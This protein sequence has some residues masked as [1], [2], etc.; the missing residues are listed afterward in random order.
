MNPRRCTCECEED[1]LFGDVYKAE[2]VHDYI[3]D[4]IDFVDNARHTINALTAFGQQTIPRDV[5]L[6]IK[7]EA[8]TILERYK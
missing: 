8:T 1:H 3:R 5:L 7:D 2:D 4:L 6:A